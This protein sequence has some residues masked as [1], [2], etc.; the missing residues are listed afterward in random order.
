MK[1]K[2]EEELVAF[3]EGIIGKSFKEI[4]TKGILQGNSNDKGI[5]GKVVETGFYDYELNNSPE[6]DFWELGIELKVSGFN[7][8]RNGSWS[9]K[10]RISLSMINY[11][12]IIHEEYEF[13]KVVSKNK[14]LLIIW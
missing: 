4:D 11:K 8:L 1:F 3:T 14:K 13:S 2:T 10:E 5:L 6:A 9:A 7:K 12:N